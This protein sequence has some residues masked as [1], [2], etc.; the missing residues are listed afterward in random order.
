MLVPVKR[1]FL[2]DFMMSP[3]DTFFDGPAAAGKQVPGLMKADV[4]ETESSFKLLIDLPG[5]KKENVTAELKDGYLEVGATTHSEVEDK[6]DKG[7]Y[8]RKERFDGKC[9]RSFYVGDDI[10]QEDVKAKFENGVLEIDVPKKTQPEIEEK[11][12]IAIEG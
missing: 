6:N 3:F 12:T 4:K 1:N 8:L 5:I 10:R 7:T 9:S 2:D 11:H